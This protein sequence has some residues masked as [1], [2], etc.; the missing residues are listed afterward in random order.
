[1]IKLL[2]QYA[3]VHDLQ[4]VSTKAASLQIK[5]P[6]FKGGKDWTLAIWLDNTPKGRVELQKVKQIFPTI[7]AVELGRSLYFWIPNTFDT[8]EKI[9]S[10]DFDDAAVS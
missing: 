5:N 10:Y 4:I 2:I 8:W 6:P 7:C 1:M 3:K 9:T